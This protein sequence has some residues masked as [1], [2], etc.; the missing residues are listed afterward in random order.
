MRLTGS[1]IIMECLLREGVH[2]MFGYPGGAILP[3]YDAMAKY[4]DRLHHVLVRHEQ[5]ASHM[6]DGYARATGEVGVCI[7]TSGPGATNLV[8]GLATAM[9]D[10]SPIVAITGQVPIPA[11]GSDAFQETDV[12]GVTLPITKHNYLVTDVDD[13]AYTMKEA[14]HIA[15]TG[16]PGPVLVDVP[17][18]V[19]NAVTEFIYPEGPIFLPGYDPPAAADTYQIDAALRLI[20]QAERPIILAGHGIIMSGAMQE[21]RELAERA[22]IPV[23]LTLLGK[24]AL[25]EDHPLVIGM[26]G[27]HGE[28]SSNLAIQEADL[29]IALGMRFDDRVT[30]NLKT[31]AVN[32][33]KIH[34]DIDRSEINK[35][36]RADVGIA[37]DLKTVLKQLLPKLERKSHPDWIHQIRDWLEDSSERDILNYETPGRLLT[38]QVINDI[39]RLTGGDAITVTDVG[40][41]QMLEAQYYPHQRPSTLLTSGG[42]GTMGFGFPAAI[43]AKFGVPDEEIWAIVGDGGFQMTLCELATARQENVNVN[44]AIINNHFLGMVRQWQELFFEK[45]YQATPMVNPDFCKLAD[46]YGIPN[47]RV[48]QRDEIE[49][50]VAYARGIDGPTLIEFVVEKEEMVYP[51]VPAG[52]DLHDMKRR[53]KPGE[54]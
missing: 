7:A 4:D 12:T 24:G 18:D 30:G 29:L 50:A 23:A 43:G 22:Q 36:V 1:E 15:R 14:F 10:S 27:M 40:Q 31:Y 46:A 8:T 48:T 44:I 19:Q 2:V 39:W 42:L 33:R 6:A 5:G 45:R 47:R 32:A 37:G 54:S 11:I 3:T 41:H 49:A 52:A 16:R 21:V 34:I 9:M 25:P 13:L 28:A 20:D 35:N 51:M 38:A 26:M 53:P 17:K